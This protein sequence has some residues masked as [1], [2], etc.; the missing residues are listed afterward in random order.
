VRAAMRAA[1]AA[2][3]VVV[4]FG[5]APPP[6]SACSCAGHENPRSSLAATAGAFVGTLERIDSDDDDPYGSPSAFHFAVEHDVKG[7]LGNRVV[8]H[9]QRGDGGSCGLEARVGERVGLFLQRKDG[10]WN[11]NLCSTVDPD[12][13]LAAAQPLPAPDG[14]GP[15]TFVVGVALGEH[16]TMLLD[17]DGRSLAYGEAP[18]R[19]PTEVAALDVCPGGARVVE[20]LHA[21]LAEEDSPI[22]AVRAVDGLRVERVVRL[23]DLPDVQGSFAYVRSVACRDA[24][25]TQLDVSLVHHTDQQTEGRVLR[26]DGDTWRTVWKAVEGEAALSDD[27]GR[28][29]VWRPGVVARLDLATGT[30]TTLHRHDGLAGAALS[31]GGRWAAVVENG[32][33]TYRPEELLVFDMGTGAV[34]AR[35]GFDPA[36]EMVEAAWADDDTLAA[37]D[38]KRLR[39]FDAGLRAVGTVTGWDTYRLLA[40]AGRVYGVR[41][42]GQPMLVATRDSTTAAEFVRLPD[43]AV[44]AIAVVPGEGPPGATSTTTTTTAP[45][46]S[47][48]EER[49]VSER[50]RSSDGPW[51]L[52]GVTLLLLAVILLA[53]RARTSFRSR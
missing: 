22:V 6:A 38:G 47:L 53:L 1:A 15:P 32:A 24:A 51:G 28:A 31:P 41:Y 46:V 50:E 48:A 37:A 33:S 34:H 27:A 40:A 3:M 16:S 4:L 13:L 20:G 52:A 35:H 14:R 25:A 26:S 30:V 39:F 43:G 7:A 10:Q 2:V 49:S 5:V 9:A 17:D 8:I 29:L 36:E 18:G 19:P 44:R 45:P 42:Q 23:G 21:A 11:A 12:R